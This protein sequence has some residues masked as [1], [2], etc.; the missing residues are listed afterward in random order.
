MEL[1]VIIKK[2]KRYLALAGPARFIRSCESG[3]PNHVIHN[4]ALMVGHP[5]GD[6]CV[7]RFVSKQTLALGAP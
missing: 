4:A 2:Q 7:V 5:D 1:V 3:P 6:A